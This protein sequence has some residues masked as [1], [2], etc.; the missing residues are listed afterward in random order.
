MVIVTHRFH[1]NKAAHQDSHHGRPKLDAHEAALKIQS[2]WRGKKARRRVGKMQPKKAHKPWGFYTHSLA[3]VSNSPNGLLSMENPSSTRRWVWLLL[4]EPSSSP[5]AHGL[6]LFIIFFIVLSIAG[7]CLETVPTMYRAS[8]MAWETLEVV[9]TVV[10]SIEY[11]GRLAVCEENATNPPTTHLRWM[12]TPMNVFDLMAVLP[13]YVELIL[14]A[15]GAE[16]TPALR[17]FRLVRL[18]R[19]IRIF[20]LGRYATGMRLFGEALAGSTTALSVLVFLLGMGVVLFSSALFYVEKMSCPNLEDLSIAE[21]TVYHGE[22]AEDFNRGWSPSIGLCCTEESSP[23]DFPSAVSAFW[24]SLVTMTSVGYGEVY[25]RTTMGKLVG[26][27]AM[28]AGMVLIALPVAIVG[29]KFQDV[30]DNH[31]LDEAKRR[32]AMRMKVLGE[33]WSLVPSSDCTSQHTD[34]RGVLPKLRALKIKDQ[35]LGDNVTDLC[36]FL[37]EVWE[38]REQ[39]MRERKYEFERQEEV[40]GRVGK[41]LSEMETAILDS[42]F[43]IGDG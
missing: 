34:R 38:Q 10:F 31:D 18:V 43:V 3:L 13:F 16:D 28:L 27:V 39:L 12:V 9:C 19:V 35:N 2:C 26:F 23:N 6:S 40:H 25:P 15:L 32:A 8:P 29:Q 42:S 21:A 7:F 14:G 1:H 24:W 11:I 4:E 22:C 36:S 5:G 30:Y 37:E 33:V 41:L 20:K 17:L